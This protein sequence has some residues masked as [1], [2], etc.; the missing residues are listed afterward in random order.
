MSEEKPL[1]VAELI[2]ALRKLDPEL[3]VHTEG[4]D[5]TGPCTGVEVGDDGDGDGDYILLTR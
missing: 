1:T 3:R 2:E 4:C 5:C